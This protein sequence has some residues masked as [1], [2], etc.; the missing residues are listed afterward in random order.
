MSRRAFLRATLASAAAAAATPL[1][2]QHQAWAAPQGQANSPV[3]IFFAETGHNI[4][5]KFR[6]YYERNGGLSVFGFPLTEVLSDGGVQVQYFERARFELRPDLPDG[7]ALSLLG[8]EL[9]AGRSDAAFTW[10]TGDPGNG[11]RY[12]PEAGHSIGGAFREYWE[13]SNGLVIFGYPISEELQEVAADGVERTVQYFQRARFEL[14]PEFSFTPNAIQLGHLGRQMLERRSDLAYATAPATPL[15]LLGKATTG[16]RGSSYERRTNIQRAAALFDG[17]QVVP[18]EE[19]SF[20]G[21]HDFSEAAGFVE[22]YGIVGG[23]L[24]RVIGGGLCQVSTTLFRAAANAGM[25]ITR[26]IGHTYMV[27]FY[28][29]VPGFDATVFSPSLDFRWRNDSPSPV[30]IISDVDLRTATVSFEI[31]GS[32]DGRVT[33]YEGPQISNKVEPGK[34]TWQFDPKMAAGQKNQLVH[35]RPGMFVRLTRTIT[36]ADGSQLRRETFSTSYKPW[37]DFWIYGPGVI[38]PADAIVIK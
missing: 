14:Y 6:R 23:K 28:E 3:P 1:L 8:S 26:R 11:R 32:S 27:Y 21:N 22:G 29:N 19:H 9:T 15:A 38:P 24:D 4:G 36:R 10:L 20:L 7:V 16:F 31:Y 18:G 2:G 17:Q 33:S 5:F 37:A 13:R 30:T 12:F 34:A 25:E 35:G